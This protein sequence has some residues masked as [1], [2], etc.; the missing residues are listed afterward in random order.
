VRE[1][2]WLVV[3]FLVA[4][5][6]ANSLSDVLGITSLRTFALATVASPLPRAFSQSASLSGFAHELNIELTAADGAVIR[7]TESPELYAGL[8]GPYERRVIYGSALSFGPATPQRLFP[9]TLKYGFCNS[10]PLAQRMGLKE[11]LQ[12][13]TVIGDAP[14]RR[15]VVPRIVVNCDNAKRP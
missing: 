4:I 10:G 9:S 7:R 2:H 14:S 11:P 8:P 12:A 1:P 6:I 15:G 5:G 3:S 13:A